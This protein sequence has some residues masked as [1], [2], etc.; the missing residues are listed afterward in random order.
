MTA[1]LRTVFAVLATLL[2]V[3]SAAAEES[4]PAQRHIVYLHGAIVEQGLPAISPRY[5]AYEFERIVTALEESG[6]SVHAPLRSAPVDVE[7]H[8]GE[9]AEHVKSL[10]EAGTNPSDITV[11]GASK[12]AYIAM[13]VN[14]RLGDTALN[15][16][17]LA[18]C[19][20]GIVAAQLANGAELY[21]R[22]LTVRDSLDTRIAG[23]CA[24]LAAASASLSEFREIV[25]ETGLEHGLIYTPR[26]EWLSPALAWSAVR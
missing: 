11:F 1:V 24:E 22:V 23:S 4:E 7:A 3:M 15:Y 26:P 18:G 20:E 10:M 16:V 6:A 17:L 9:I 13:R 21:G 14:Q 12:G 25:V 8:A 19:S 5:G 2:A